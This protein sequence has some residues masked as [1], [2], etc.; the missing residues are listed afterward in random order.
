MADPNNVSSGP[1]DDL[2][3]EV[4]KRKIWFYE[5]HLRRLNLDSFRGITELDRG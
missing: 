2:S 1:A 3:L 4:E 5:C